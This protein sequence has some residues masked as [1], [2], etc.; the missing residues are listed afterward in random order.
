MNQIANTLN[1][2]KGNAKLCHHKNTKNSLACISFCW[3]P[4]YQYDANTINQYYNKHDHIYYYHKHTKNNN[5]NKQNKIVIPKK[6]TGAVFNL[7]K[8]FIT[9]LQS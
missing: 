5:A 2:T 3:I 9:K 4:Q 1:L 7:F 6:Q 8:L